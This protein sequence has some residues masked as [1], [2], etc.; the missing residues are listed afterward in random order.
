M[1]FWV[2]RFKPVFDVTMPVVVQIF[3][4]PRPVEAGAPVV[5]LAGIGQVER[6]LISPFERLPAASARAVGTK[7]TE[8]S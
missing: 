3:K 4:R 2:V 1:D 5:A 8:Q 7:S 6:R